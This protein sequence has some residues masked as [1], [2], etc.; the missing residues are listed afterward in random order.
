VS[1]ALLKKMREMGL[2]MDQAIELMDVWEAGVQKPVPAPSKAALRTRRWRENRHGDVTVTHHGDDRPRVSPTPPSDNP[3]PPLTGGTFPEIGEASPR[4]RSGKA[5]LENALRAAARRGFD[6]AA[7]KRGVAGYYASHDATKDQGQ[8]A[9][10]VHVAVSSGRWEAFA[11]D[12][13]NAPPAEE[14]P[15]P[16]RLLNWRVNAYW[17]SE[18]GPKP[19]K[20][21]YLGPPPEEIAA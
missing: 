7:V 21:G 15:W 5:S 14:D 12:E 3:I 1:A 17:N 18:W 16:R 8:F 13:P 9:Q 11:E 10:G 2:S 4:E 6:L 19:G 20:P